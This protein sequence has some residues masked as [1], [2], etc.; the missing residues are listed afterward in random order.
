MILYITPQ[1]R[2][3]RCWIDERIGKKGEIM[4]VLYL[5]VSVLLLVSAVGAAQVKEK[6]LLVFS[7]HPEYSWVIEETRG[8]EDV[9]EGKGI[10]NKGCG[11]RF[12]R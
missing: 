2:S 6:V 7:Y 10:T 11:G 1:V 4:K 8:V 9:L 5:M 12:R 3:P